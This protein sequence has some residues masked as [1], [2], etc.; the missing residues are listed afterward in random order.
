MKLQA[1]NSVTDLQPACFNGVGIRPLAGS[2][3][4]GNSP[5]KKKGSQD[6]TAPDNYSSSNGYMAYVPDPA[7][8]GM[9]IFWPMKT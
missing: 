9:V 3:M 1:D 6:L 4:G 5:A 8:A 2:P 7:A